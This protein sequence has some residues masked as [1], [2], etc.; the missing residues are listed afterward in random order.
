MTRCV[1]VIN[2]RAWV[3]RGLELASVLR[4]GV[5]GPIG[6]P[7]GCPSNPEDVMIVVDADYWSG[8]LAELSDAVLDFPNQGD[9]S[10]S[11]IGAGL[12]PGTSERL[13][14]SVEQAA[15]ALGI[16][17]ASAYEAVHRGEIPHIK[18]GKRMLIPRAS[19]DR[20]LASADRP[21]SRP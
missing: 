17:R 10:E 9:R 16:S 3:N 4:A 20:L 18:I 15:A 5:L 7:D 19:L 14:L 11:P 8:Q 1:V 13:T 6:N 21:K 12:A 2:R